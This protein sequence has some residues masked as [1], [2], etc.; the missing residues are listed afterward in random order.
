MVALY[1]DPDGDNVFTDHRETAMSRSS[2]MFET[3]SY[4][5]RQDGG[6]NGQSIDALRQRIQNL[7]GQLA[8]HNAVRPHEVGSHTE[9]L[10]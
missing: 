10:M 9:I 8:E 3:I 1:K 6:E 7:E 4:F 2:R 5:E